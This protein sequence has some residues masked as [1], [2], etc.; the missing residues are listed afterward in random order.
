MLVAAGGALLGAR[1]VRRR[2]RAV[3]LSPTVDQQRLHHNDERAHCMS[4]AP[5][6]RNNLTS[7]M[8]HCKKKNNIY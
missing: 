7:E 8:K 5:T 2:E 3:E 1:R 6:I 4:L